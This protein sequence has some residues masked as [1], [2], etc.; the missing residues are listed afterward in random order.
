MLLPGGVVL[1]AVLAFIMLPRQAADRES[2]IE[3]L[4]SVQ[5][6]KSERGSLHRQQIPETDLPPPG[7]R[8]LFDHL[9]RENGS[10]PF[11]FDRVIDMIAA[12]DKDG[13]QARSLLIPDGRSLLKG[14]AH[15]AGPR[16]VLAATAQAPAGAAVSPRLR[17]RLFLGFVEDA[18]EIEVISYNEVAGRFEFQLVENYCA[19][20]VP[21]IVYAKRAICTTCHTGGAPIFPVRPWQETNVNPQISQRL[22]AHLDGPD[23]FGLPL[24]RPLDE[25]Q[26]FDDLTD[27]ANVI[28]TTQKI[29]LDGCGETGHACRREMLRLALTYALNPSALDQ[30]GLNKDTEQL[31]QLQAQAWPSGG[32]LLANGD[33]NNRDPL[34]QDLYQDPWWKQ[35]KN[36][37]IEDSKVVRSGDKLSDFDQLP[38]LAAQFDPLTPRRP[39]KQIRA[40]ELDGVYGLAQMFSADDI[41][42]LEALADYDAKKLSQAVADLSELLFDPEPF[43]RVQMLNALAS[44]L[45]AEPRN[46]CCDDVS[47][48]SPPIAQG[49]PPLSLAEGSLLRPFETYCFACH[50]GN[51]SARLNFMS[52]AD[53]KTVL[54]G[55]QDTSEIREVLDYQ[56]YLGTRKENS[57]MPPS[58]SWQRQ[59]LLEA[60]QQGQEPLSAMRDQ[61]PSLFEF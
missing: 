17:G 6:S 23:Y 10:L 52:G 21:R 39:K 9:I 38:K 15:F 35:L 60:Q 32:I 24:Q 27:M 28:P 3:A 47:E 37:F 58:D 8:S 7:T 59:A 20:C 55:I 45:G 53:E 11:P 5:A 29:W 48:M 51:P 46:Y 12:Y 30:S 36:L 4:A 57:L 56:R 33:L 1:L 31:L 14:Q 61:V 50:R 19:G 44:A 43:Q 25:A 13:R 2:S 16:I 40:Q 54:A 34:N 26:A 22:A 49:E 18:N 41:A 42:R